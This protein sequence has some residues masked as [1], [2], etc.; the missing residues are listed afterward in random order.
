MT[1]TNIQER[2]RQ[3]MEYD[4]IRI[5][6]D[7][8]DFPEIRTKLLVAFLN[9]ETIDRPRAE[10]F[11]LV[12]SLVQVGLDTHD[13]VPETNDKKDKPEARSRQLKV[14]AGDYFSARFYQLLSQT[15]EI[16]VVKQLSKSIC[17]VNRLKMNFYTLMKQLKM[18][19]E[20]YL[21]H[22][23]S[24]KMQLFL[25]FQK[26][27]A[28]VCHRIWPEI[29]QNYTR[30]EV[31]VE[32]LSR[33]NSTDQI[34]GSWAYW[35]IMQFGTKEDKK[36]LQAEGIDPGKL[37]ALLMKYNVKAQLS[38]MLELQIDH[39]RHI[40]SELTP[41]GLGQE[42][43]TVGDLLARYRNKPKVREEV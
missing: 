34:K 10:L 14:L 20:D 23:I 28:G 16:E 2:A 24:I 31:L 13:Q 6:T 12:T 3:Y 30:C 17:E 38:Q 27:M 39:L 29:L 40:V 18:S 5:H 22:T 21:Q 11:A 4:M 42:L 43:Q 41:E 37:R 26:W 15:G 8:P 36:Q 1:N 19:A 9:T 7:L 32:E 33:L 35:Y 25:T